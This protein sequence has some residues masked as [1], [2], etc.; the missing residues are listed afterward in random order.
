MSLTY[1][2]ANCTWLTLWNILRTWT[3]TDAGLNAGSQ[4]KASFPTMV[5]SK[6]LNQEKTQLTVPKDLIHGRFCGFPVLGKVPAGSFNIYLTVLGTAGDR[7]G[8]SKWQG[9]LSLSKIKFKDERVK[10]KN[11]NKNQPNQQHCPRTASWSH[12]LVPTQAPSYRKPPGTDP[13]WPS[14]ERGH[15]CA[16]STQAYSQ[17]SRNTAIQGRSQSTRQPVSDTPAHLPPGQLQP[18]PGVSPNSGIQPWNQS[19]LWT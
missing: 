15:L 14:M 10:G 16:A 2:P 19:L 4:W 8:P 12:I 13:K 5:I 3:D 18:Y 9:K 11:K 7:S 6:M 17:L 1:S